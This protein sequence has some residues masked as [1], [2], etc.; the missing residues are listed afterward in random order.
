M[1]KNKMRFAAAVLAFLFVVSSAPGSASAAVI[2]RSI[3]PVRLVL[4]EPPVDDRVLQAFDNGGGTD[5]FFTQQVGS[6]TRLSRCSRTTA[7]KCVQRDSV[8]LPNYGHGESLEVFTKNG[9]TY[10]WVG[11]GAAPI[12]PFYPSRNISLVEYIKAPSGSKKATY[13]RVGTLTN[14]AAVAPGKSGMP[15]GSSV[16]LADGTNRLALRVR[17][18]ASMSSTYYG[19]YKTGALIERMK[20]SPGQRLSI[21]KASDLRVTRFKEPTRPYNS[22]QGFDIKGAGTSTKFIYLFG[23]ATG[24]T[25]MI[26]RFIYSNDGNIRHDRTYNITGSFIGTNEA[27]G[28]KVEADPSIGGKMRVQIGI[29]PKAR[30][31]ANRKMYRLYRF[32][33]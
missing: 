24:Q 8:M 33:E 5:V 27:E 1:K 10:A 28:V 11:S 20:K 18:V 7:G 3:T 21:S 15:Y 26:Y 9:R 14:L 32:A 12:P 13:R 23:G 19:I 2:K 31:A 22:F 4:F 29:N 16:A 6:S 25:P 17:V 30:D